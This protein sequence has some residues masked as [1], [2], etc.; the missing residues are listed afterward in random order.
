M[1]TLGLVQLDSVNVCIRSHYMPFYS[2]L[3]EYDQTA[4]D[5]WLN[6]SGE[7]FEY[8]AHAAA[9]LPVD[10]YPRWRWK[11]G[12]K[13]VWRRAEALL[14]AHPELLDDV[15]RQVHENGP[16]T[17]RDL[18]APIH[19]NDPWWGYGPG[20]IALEVLFANGDI[21]ALRT[22]NFTRLYDAPDRMIDARFL[23]ADAMTK[24]EA[25][26]ALLRD[27]VKHVGI[28]T[29]HDI[30]DYFRLH[31]SRSAPFLTEMADRGEIEEVEIREWG[32][33]VYL[34]PGAVRPRQISGAT[35]L[36]PFDP[37]TWYRERAERL[38]GFEY[39]IEI[40]VPEAKRIYG[41]YT[42]PFLLDGELVGRVDLKADR[43]RNALLVQSAWQ[44]EGTDPRR[45]GASL[46][47]ELKTFARWL[48]L[49][50]IE[51]ANRGNLSGEIA[52]LL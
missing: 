3:G 20:K 35:L 5:L 9:V 13:T 27:A 14:D 24:D 2:R 38:F 19:Q 47:S 18:D 26:R 34:D 43:K 25:Y 44:E 16:L 49:D 7:N 37:V 11:M 40:Y 8:W 51:V 12:E 48:Q 36:S 28:G 30:A 23:S 1:D 21:A 22:K 29:V 52:K 50:S 31:S 15:K 45:I 33:P 6:E 32:G 4:L 17:I 46:A 41:Y 39:R 10:R 42:L